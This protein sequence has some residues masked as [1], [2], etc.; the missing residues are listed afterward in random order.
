MHCKGAVSM[1]LLPHAR[2]MYRRRKTSH[3][4]FSRPKQALLLPLCAYSPY[5]PPR[6]V[7]YTASNEVLI[8]FFSVSR[9]P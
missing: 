7:L 6:S 1:R 8:L 2:A 9:P 4:L 5:S 3:I